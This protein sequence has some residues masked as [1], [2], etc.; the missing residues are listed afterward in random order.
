[1]STIHVLSP[2]LFTT[3]QDLGREGFGA[4]GVSASGAADPLAL[5]IGNRLVAN[6]ENAAALEITLVGGTLL[7]PEG[8]VIAMTGSDF[9]ATL[10]REPLPLWSSQ[11]VN[12]GQTLRFESTD[13]GARCYLC[14]QGGIAVPLFLGSASTH[15]LSGLGGLEG[16]PLRKGDVLNIGPADRSFRRRSV[17]PDALQRLFPRR[18]LR[19]TPGPQEKWF[20]ESE[21]RKLLSA[22]YSVSEESNRMGLRL[23]GPALTL[24]EGHTN[25]EMITEGVSLG[26]IQIPEGGLP[27][28]LFV[29]QQTTGGYPKV[30]NVIAADLPSVGQLRPRDRI[31]FELVSWDM[32]R[33]VLQEQEN[34]L[35]SADFIVE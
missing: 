35:A 23:K 10:D 17:V 14:V 7:F 8:A 5:R 26:A 2:G 25:G 22:E 18:L 31:Q 21:F 6:T 27:I 34:I 29:E 1:M 11:S 16:R 33:S 13:S 9:G 12:P 3:V 4:L 19:V 28:I 24:A 30:A 15:I 20:P 32:A